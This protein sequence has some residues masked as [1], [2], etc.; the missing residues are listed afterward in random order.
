MIRR[1]IYKAY[2]EKYKREWDTLY[3]AIDLHG[4]IIKRYT[5][6]EIIPYDWAAKTL[7]FLT[8]KEDIVLILYTAT[9]FNNLKP[10]Y[11]WCCEEEIEFSHLNE[12]PECPSNK[13]GDFKS[14]FYFNVLIDDRAGFDPDN[15]GW[16][17]IQKAVKIASKMEKCKAIQDCIYGLNDKCHWYTCSKCEELSSFDDNVESP[18]YKNLKEFIFED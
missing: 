6:S 18:V 14:K 17:N 11:E 5:G 1:A 8:L 7:R 13:M 10:F 3:F 9:Y 4:T 2:Q 12:N 15:D 16:Y